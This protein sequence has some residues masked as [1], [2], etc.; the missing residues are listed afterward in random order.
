MEPRGGG[1]DGSLCR[2][3]DQ[4]EPFLAHRSG[5]AFVQPDHP[6]RCGAAFRGNER[7]GELQR[8]GCPQGMDAQES[9]RVLADNLLG[10]TSCQASAISLSRWKASSALFASS[11]ASRSRRANAEAHFTADPHHASMSGSRCA[12]ACR[13]SVVVTAT[14]SGKIAEASQNFTGLPGV[15]RS[16]HGPPKRRR[17]RAPTGTGTAPALNRCDAAVR[18]RRG[19]AAIACLPGRIPQPCPTDRAWCRKAVLHENIP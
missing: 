4:R 9:E 17:E 8:I 18:H 19:A 15:P 11:A 14:S 6:K 1:E 12:S 2:N 10:S 7:R 16:A 13:R 3:V 5:K